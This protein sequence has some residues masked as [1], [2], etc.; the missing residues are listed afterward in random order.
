M[1]VDE[2]KPKSQMWSRFAKAWHETSARTIVKDELK[3][4]ILNSSILGAPRIMKTQH[5]TIAVFWVFAIVLLLSATVYFTT[6][7]VLE[8]FKYNT[9]VNIREYDP[10]NIDDR[11]TLKQEYGFD[12]PAITVC[13]EFQ[14]RHDYED[15]LPTTPFPILTK[16]EYLDALF[17][18]LDA[19]VDASIRSELY[20]NAY[21]MY[22]YVY[23][24][25]LH[26]NG[27]TVA[28]TKESF[29]VTCHYVESDVTTGRR[30]PCSQ[31][32]IVERFYVENLLTCFKVKVNESAMNPDKVVGLS[33]I[34]YLDDF[35][36]FVPHENFETLNDVQQRSGVKLYM[37]DSNAY[38]QSFD[39]SSRFAPGQLVDVETKMFAQKELPEPYGNC[40]ERGEE[41]VEEL[42][43]PVPYSHQAC[44]KACQHRAVRQECQCFHLV[45]NIRFKRDNE[46]L[47]PCHFVPTFE[48]L[49]QTVQRLQ[50]AQQAMEDVRQTCVKNCL[51][52]CTEIRY[53]FEYTSD[54]W[55][56]P[57]RQLALYND[58]I[59][60]PALDVMSL[61]GCTDVNDC[62]QTAS[63]YTSEALITAQSRNDVIKR[64]RNFKETYEP[65]RELAA[66]GNATQE[67]VDLLLATPLV[68]HNFVK[69]SIKF[70]DQSF[71]AYESQ[72][73][74]N[75]NNLLSSLGGILNL[76][77]GI[78]AVLVFELIELCG[79]LVI[80]WRNKR[81]EKE[82]Q[83]VTP[84]NV[85]HA[86][87]N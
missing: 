30:I 80:S 26:L 47:L 85:V 3:Q 8:Y 53:S 84:L 45:L 55:P 68:E 37:H 36:Y 19:D 7:I 60:Q 11:R 17:A 24:H 21:G 9:K 65:I 35:Q 62:H 87:A 15:D 77:A 5:R 22:L 58:L 52:N 76:Y 38:A 33:M 39:V 74:M 72:A 40:S 2:K 14:T 27:T 71:L 41:L 10:Q 34:L 57:R 50:C 44:V 67:V 13:N 61:V 46:Q 43:Q 31:S 32:A 64:W 75:V 82:R 4:F 63:E 59:R 86:Q 83:R 6:N 56:A 73:A 16:E 70:G 79:H 49:N 18:H 69:L 48:A 29:V 23:T 12:F 54:K 51:K 66:A 28:Q 78:T 25:L 20:N 42:G 81:Q 1:S